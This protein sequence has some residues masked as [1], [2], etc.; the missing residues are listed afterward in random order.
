M[1]KVPFKSYSIGQMSLLTQS[2]DELIP[3]GH[4]VRLVNAMLDR[5]AITR[6]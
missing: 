5:I 6:C 3:E 1:R 4:L 2:P